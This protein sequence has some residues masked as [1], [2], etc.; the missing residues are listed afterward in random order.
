MVGRP[1]PDTGD[2]IDQ[3]IVCSDQVGGYALHRAIYI[4]TYLIEQLRAAQAFTGE[5]AT[6]LGLAG[7]YGNGDL[8]LGNAGGAGALGG[9]QGKGAEV[10]F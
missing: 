8:F 4:N 5:D 9:G 1:V 2:G 10:V 3:L 6:D 7:G